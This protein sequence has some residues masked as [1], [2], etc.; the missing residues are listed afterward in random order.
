[1]YDADSVIQCKR[2]ACYE[3]G[4]HMPMDIAALAVG[5]PEDIL[6]KKWA[7]DV[8]GALVAIEA[9]L[10][11]NPPAPLKARLQWEQVMLPRLVRQYPHNKEKAM[12][13]MRELIPDFTFAEFDRLE[14]ENA[15]DFVYVGGEKRYFVRFHRTLLKVNPDIARRAGRPLTPESPLL[16]EA[17]REMKEKGGLACRFQ[18]R[19][20][21][22]VDGKAFIPGETYRVHLPLPAASAQTADAKIL[23]CSFQPKFV[24]P[25]DH[26]QRTAYFEE[27]LAENK[28][29]VMEYGYESAMKYVD[30]KKPP[31]LNGPAYPRCPAPGAEDLGELAPHILFTPYLKALAADIRGEET[32]PVA[33]ARRIYDFITT[34]VNYSFVRSYMTIDNQAEY[35]AINLKG[36]CGLQALLF[37]TLCRICGIP[38]RWQSSLAAEPDAIGSHDWAQFYLE[39]WG[40]VFCDCS[41]GGAAWRKGAMERW[42]FYFGNLDPYRMAANSQ[43]QAEFEPK[44]KHVRADPYDNQD[45][46]CECGLK[47]FDGFEL[48]TEYTMVKWEKV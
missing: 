5:L 32:E 25:S 18:I 19:C 12:Q 30:L 44:K 3:R 36:D 10:A 16:D 38:A 15:L 35:A 20:E 42:D 23:A 33:V 6:K 29:F 43:Y 31:V 7:G 24:S 14:N 39:P 41:Y 13:L 48:D 40:W 37:I 22:K 34:R 26:P 4:I 1:M 11:K 9:R 2:K 46:E 45:G 17:I 8:E 21:L 28:P 47:G 27:T